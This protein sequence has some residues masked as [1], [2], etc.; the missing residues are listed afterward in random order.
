MKVIACSD[1]HYD[2]STAGLSRFDDVCAAME[3]VADEA[4]SKRAALFIF[5]GDLAE[6]SGPGMLRGLEHAVH[7]AS[8]LYAKGIP[9]LWLPGN[10]DVIEDG[11]RTSNLSPLRC[12]PGAT[13]ADDPTLRL[14]AIQGDRPLIVA[15]LPFAPRTHD[16]D[17]DAW[18]RAHA[19]PGNPRPDLVVG[20]LM[21]EGIGPGSETRDMPR[22]RNVFWPLAAVEQCWPDAVKVAGHYHA[23]QVYRGVHV[24]GSLVRLMR[25]EASNQPCYLEIDL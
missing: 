7:T 24:V 13:L 12:V 19:E 6:A 25:V 17:P 14:V 2:W 11:H 10:H 3:F 16:Y 1:A 9:S 22:G 15:A 21:L 4:I 5:A 23:P 18:V 8:R 20:H